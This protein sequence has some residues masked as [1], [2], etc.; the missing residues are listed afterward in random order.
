MV[1]KRQ[2][3]NFGRHFK[4][5]NEQQL[6]QVTRRT[7][8]VCYLSLHFA[9]DAL[10][11]VR[12]AG[13]DDGLTARHPKGIEAG[14]PLLGRLA[15][16]RAERPQ[17]LGVPF[18]DRRLVAFRR[19]AKHWQIVQDLVCGYVKMRESAPTNCIDENPGNRYTSVFRPEV[20]F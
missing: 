3:G 8:L 14:P 17:R 4:M 15:L 10:E 5:N 1:K 16:S 7:C 6:K 18:V 20:G 12:K 2:I 9:D 19:P 13:Q 11:K